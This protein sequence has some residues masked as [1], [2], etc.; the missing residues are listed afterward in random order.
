MS[1]SIISMFNNV[2]AETDLD[3]LVK[4]A[5]NEVTY[6]RFH[7][8]KLFIKKASTMFKDLLDEFKDL[9][10]ITINV[11]SAKDVQYVETILRHCYGDN[12]NNIFMISKVLVGIVIKYQFNELAKDCLMHSEYMCT[13]E[14][15]YLLNLDR[16]CCIAYG[17]S[18][19]N[20]DAECVVKII[21][22]VM[23]NFYVHINCGLKL[24]RLKHHLTQLP[25]KGFI[26]LLD[27]DDGKGCMDWSIVVI[28]TWYEMHDNVEMFESFLRRVDFYRLT[29][30]YRKVYLEHVVALN[31]KT[32]TN[33]LTDIIQE[34]KTYVYDV[35]N[36]EGITYSFNTDDDESFDID[37]TLEANL[38][39]L[40][41]RYDDCKIR[42]CTHA[43]V[44]EN[45]CPNS[46]TKCPEH[47]MC[48]RLMI[49]LIDAK[50][51]KSIGKSQF[52]YTKIKKNTQYSHSVVNIKS[53]NL[54]PQ[55]DIK[56]KYKGT[57]TF[58]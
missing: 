25:L 41:L 13:C 18:V 37:E 33:H 8:H 24:D 56:M 22:N 9:K 26:Y 23:K 34:Y 30:P 5:S 3:V 42:L 55:R 35:F 45:T 39:R 12:I 11:N 31:S 54:D 32:L 43:N 38:P 1:T 29:K 10:E 21:K 20:C 48:V 15:D 53:L 14:D 51:S 52:V 4:D 57:M 7:V 50:S 2:D 36:F 16:L 17:T 28:N 6:G 49:E 46:D 44:F 27:M 58:H 19:W 40:E 47:L